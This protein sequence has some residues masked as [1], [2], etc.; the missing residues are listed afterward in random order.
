MKST[1]KITKLKLNI[2]QNNDYRLL[3]IV[4][5][6]PDYK[7]SLSLNKKFGISLKNI[8]P[9]KLT[10]DIQSELAFSRFSNNDDT[11]DLNFSLISNR[12][13]KNFLLN[14]LKNIDY[15]LQIQ[16][17]EKESDLNTITSK[18]RE[19]DS[20]TAVFNIDLDTMKDKNLHYL[21]Q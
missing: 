18:L 14:K 8:S 10:G 20:V 1:K 16:I 6:E 9:L 15:L 17:S 2:D 3:G 21:T 7:L 19:I 12:T 5:A 4:S 13:N 11:S